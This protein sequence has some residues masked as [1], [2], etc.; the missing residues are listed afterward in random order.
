MSILPILEQTNEIIGE[1]DDIKMALH[2]QA[3]NKSY[4]KRIQT[5]C[6][7]RLC[8]AL[9]VPAAA[10]VMVLKIH[11]RM[12]KLKSSLFLA[13]KDKIIK[14]TLGAELI[15]PPSVPETANAFSAMFKQKRSV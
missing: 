8:L 11:N 6:P 9:V 3:F 1:P 13:H 14:A 15:A 4:L 12:I 10:G 2:L 7:R 5:N